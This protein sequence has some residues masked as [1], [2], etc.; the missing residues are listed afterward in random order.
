MSLLVVTALVVI[1]DQ[2]TKYLIRTNFSLHESVPVI[3]NFFHFTYVSN[4]GMVFG[5]NFPGAIYF[6]T[7]ASLILTGFLFWYFWH[8]RNKS[9]LLRLSLALIVAGAV[10]NLID[11]ILFR[12]VVDFLDFIF[13]GWHFY[14]FNIADSAVTVGISIYL[15]YIFFFESSDK[16]PE[17]IS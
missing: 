10:G 13:W 5:I 8:E 17:S 3:E 15:I 12:E 9:I 4:D 1:A 7:I 2:V 14:I 11:R 16:L 6:S